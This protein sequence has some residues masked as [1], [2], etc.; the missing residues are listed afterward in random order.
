MRAGTFIHA[1][2]D[3]S[4]Y[5]L[6]DESAARAADAI[7]ELEERTRTLRQSGT[8][9]AET[10]RNYFGETRFQQVAESNAIEGSTL[11]VG[12][13]EL[14]ILKG[15]TLTGHEPHFVRDARQLH[16]ALG[17]LLELADSTAP[18][19]VLSVRELHKLILG[20]RAAAGEYRTVPVTIRGSEHR[21]PR[22]PHQIAA[23]M[24]DWER[25]SLRMTA[26]PP[27][28]RAT[29]LH[30][31][32]AH[33]HPF[34]DGN[35]RTSRAVSTLELIRGGLPPAIIRKTQDRGRYLQALSESDAGGN[36]GPFLD[37]M[38]SRVDA[39]LVGLEQAARKHQGFDP[40]AVRLRAAQGRKVQVW[41]TAVALLYQMVVDRLGGALEEAGGRLESHLYEKPLSEEEYADLCG[42]KPIGQRWAFRLVLHLPGSS[43]LQ[44]LCWVGFRTE[45]LSSKDGNRGAPSLFW[46][47]PNPARFPQW[48]PLDGEDEPV[49]RELSILLE[50]GDRWLLRDRD[51]ATL[52]S[53]TSEAADAIS[54]A[55][56]RSLTG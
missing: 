9:S 23:H 38:L 30:A 18:T 49:W 31:W 27:L 42:G 19:D 11:D 29:V 16:V 10:L 14:A 7:Q 24:L 47:K 40:L 22:R 5:S 50:Q 26:A 35:G 41:Q 32:L 20:A 46:S 48:N 4:I 52:E 45:T 28:L 1:M 54:Q 3:G 17:R 33:I 37:L 25:W 15:V 6:D 56:V 12:E 36:I 51:G 53:S 44:R 21:P 43:P 39:A 2:L 13:T 34:E 8:L 55:L